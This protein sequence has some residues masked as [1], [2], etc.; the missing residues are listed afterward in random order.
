MQLTTDCIVLLLCCLRSKHFDTLFLSLHKQPTQPSFFYS[1]F[2]QLL[3]INCSLLT[4][5]LYYI[6]PKR[7]IL[8]C[9]LRVYPPLKTFKLFMSL[10]SSQL[11]FLFYK[12]FSQNQVLSTTQVTW[13]CITSLLKINYF[14]ILITFCIMKLLA[15]SLLNLI[16]RTQKIY[17]KTLWSFYCPFLFNQQL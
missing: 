16:S 11:H 3:R 4:F 7:T 15:T 9:S 2:L 1:Q 14:S 6:C 5:S 10:P 12:V 17:V 8:L 13:R